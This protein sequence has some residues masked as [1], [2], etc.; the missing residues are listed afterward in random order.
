MKSKFYGKAGKSKGFAKWENE[1]PSM[2]ADVDL[3]AEAPQD[4]QDHNGIETLPE[5]QESEDSW[6]LTLKHRK[7]K[8]TA[9]ASVDG[10]SQTTFGHK[11]CS[12]TSSF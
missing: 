2:Q 9:T 8:M 10:L 6:L 7:L 3:E 5:T 1:K 4:I 12:H 11:E